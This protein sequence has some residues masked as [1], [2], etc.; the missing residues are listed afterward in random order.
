MDT[1]RALGIRVA[2]DD[3]GVGNRSFKQLYTIKF[4]I[5]KIDGSFIKDI[6]TNP[7]HRF[8]TEMVVKLSKD[9][10]AKAVAEFVENGE[11]A[12]I[13]IDLGVDFMQ[14]NFFSSAQNFRSW[15]K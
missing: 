13:L 14:G 10:G 12:K 7:Y 11:V 9:T 15:H 3:F 1:V 6:A 5:I 4:D 8:I 2:L